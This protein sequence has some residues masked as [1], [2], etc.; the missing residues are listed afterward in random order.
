MGEPGTRR[1]RKRSVACACEGLVDLPEKDLS[2]EERIG[3]TDNIVAIG[4]S[5]IS[6]SDNYI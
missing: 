1:R 5:A 2:G 6:F 3:P 4:P